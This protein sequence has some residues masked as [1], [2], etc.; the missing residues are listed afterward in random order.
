MNT[1]NKT[2][3]YAS[4][5]LAS[6]LTSCD[7]NK[8]VDMVRGKIKDIKD[9]EIRIINNIKLAAQDSYTLEIYDA[10]GNIKGRL[11]FSFFPSGYIQYEDK[12]VNFRDGEAL[13]EN[14]LSYKAEK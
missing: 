12:I 10:A 5:G 3:S 4:L 2:I 11:E 9:A 1:L 8:N 6:I 13:T 14:K 7:E